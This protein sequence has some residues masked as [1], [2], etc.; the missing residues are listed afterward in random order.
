MHASKSTVG[1]RAGHL[2]DEDGGRGL[3]A[4]SPQG[5]LLEPWIAVGDEFGEHD[6]GTC[7][8]HAR[9]GVD[10][11][12]AGDGVS[13]IPDGLDDGIEQAMAVDAVREGFIDDR[14][15]LAKG[16]HGAED[17]RRAPDPVERRGDL[18]GRTRRTPKELE[19]GFRATRAV[20]VEGSFDHGGQAAVRLLGQPPPRWRRR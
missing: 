19:G 5:V 14:Q 10:R 15:D 16:A 8:G 17:G 1:D 6:R 11:G 2:R 20:D 7:A 12:Q 9:Q 4:E 18:E 3:S 13:L